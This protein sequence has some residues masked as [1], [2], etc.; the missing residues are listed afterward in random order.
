MH[1]YLELRREQKIQQLAEEQRMR[2]EAVARVQSQ[3]ERA[4][5]ERAR[6][7]EQR[8]SLLGVGIGVPAVIFGFLSINLYE[9]TA[10]DEGLSL[11][12][13]LLLG[14]GGGVLL[15]VIIWWLLRRQRRLDE[16]DLKDK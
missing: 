5:Q 13:P 10:K 7:L 8:I 2:D 6:Q 9:I 4:A 15:G 12:F 16:V 14:G 1:G 11:W 3:R